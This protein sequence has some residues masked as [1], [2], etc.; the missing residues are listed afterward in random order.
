MKLTINAE[1][2]ELGEV[3][4]FEAESG[5]TFD[6][7]TQGRTNTRALLALI[8][9]QERRKNKDYTM[10]DAR[11]IRVSEIEVDDA[12]PTEPGAQTSSID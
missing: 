1:E 2:M 8:T 5:L 11:K 6:E 12:N 4:F 3:E 10:D 7:L 9:I